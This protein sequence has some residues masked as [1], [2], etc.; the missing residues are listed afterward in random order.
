MSLEGADDFN[1]AIEEA[2][3]K[4]PQSVRA[5]LYQEGLLVQKDSMRRTP[6][7]TGVLRSTHNTELVEDG[8]IATKV[9]VGGSAAPYAHKVHEDLEAFHTVGEAKF[10]ANAANAAIPGLAERVAKR[11][12]K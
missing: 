12:K 4:L 7:D 3:K 1:K 5:A 11:L 2:I 6:V 9:T 8:D 10:L